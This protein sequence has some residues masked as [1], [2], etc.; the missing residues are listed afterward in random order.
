MRARDGDLDT[1]ST[2]IARSIHII[3]HTC[4]YALLPY[5]EATMSSCSKQ[6]T[7]TTTD[8]RG[9]GKRQEDTPPSELLLSF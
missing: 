3:A 2:T 6:T 9:Q 1:R 7:V 5:S 4:T 8:D